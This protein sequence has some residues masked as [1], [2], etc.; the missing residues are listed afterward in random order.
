MILNEYLRIDPTK[1]MLKI[2]K[3]IGEDARI[4]Y[5]TDS[6]GLEYKGKSYFK[7]NNGISYIITFMATPGTFETNL[8]LFEKFYLTLIIK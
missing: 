7:F 6:N 8:E 1:T 2:D 4:V 3:G 5:H